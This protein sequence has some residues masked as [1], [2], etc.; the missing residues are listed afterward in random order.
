MTLSSTSL[1]CP[2][3]VSNAY[4]LRTIADGENTTCHPHK[5]DVLMSFAIT[6]VASLKIALHCEVGG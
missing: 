3:Q 2:P 4:T 1:T 5:S 6:M